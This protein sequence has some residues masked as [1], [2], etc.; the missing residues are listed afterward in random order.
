MLLFELNLP[1]TPGKR[2]RFS[3]SGKAYN[4]N[5]KLIEQIKWQLKPF[6]PSS[7]LT[8]RLEVAYTFYLPLPKNVSA[9]KKRQMLNDVIGHTKRPDVDNLA[10]LITN[11]MKGIIYT[12]DSLIT[13]M[14]MFKR[15]AERPKIVIKVNPIMQMETYHGESIS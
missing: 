2:T 11:T 6:A 1:P 3:R 5:R 12:D 4:P 9:I 14:H 8:G 13:D 7:P 15:Y 10:Y